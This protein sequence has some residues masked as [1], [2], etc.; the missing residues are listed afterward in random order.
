MHV[1]CCHPGRAL[2]GG[3]RQW[4]E[5]RCK[6]YHRSQLGVASRAEL[7]PGASE[8]LDRVAQFLMQHP[9]MK[10]RIEGHTDSTGTDSY[11][12]DLSQRRADAVAH[13]LESRGAD[14]GNL[15]AVG[16]GSE[17]PVASNDT[18]AGRQ[19]NRRVE[20]VFSEAGRQLARRD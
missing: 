16:R 4:S 3:V 10:V 20:L 5:T 15:V 1:R 19:Q 6:P 12:M 8:S 11:N 7:K 18:A 2:G 13:A 9:S 14:A 17:L